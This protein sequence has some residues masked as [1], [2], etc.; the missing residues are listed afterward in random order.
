MLEQNK[1][2][3]IRKMSEKDTDKFHQ[4]YK[5]ILEESFV[6]YPP[7]AIK[8]FITEAFS[9]DFKGKKSSDWGVDVWIA[10]QAK[11]M[12]GFLMAEKLYAG[13]SFCNWLGVIKESQG[14]GIGK[15]LLK[16]WEEE[17]SRQ[18]GHKLMLLN[19]LEKNNNLYRKMGFK[20][21]GYEE[22]LWCGLDYWVFGK[23]IGEPN[24]EIYLDFSK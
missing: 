7:I 12:V 1:E 24:P 14:K 23:V 20:E 3:I 2:F 6:E 4:L 13:V 9:E 19:H 11:R 5:K 10:F 21:E 15:T 8:H 16:E 18:G 17:I 22:K